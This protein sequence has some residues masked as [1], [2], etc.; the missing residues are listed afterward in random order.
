MLTEK[1]REIDRKKLTIPYSGPFDTSF[2]RLH[3]VRYADD[4]LIGVIGSKEDAIAIKEQVKSF[5]AD[6]LKLELSD[7]TGKRKH[8]ITSRIT[9]TSKSLTSTTVKSR[10][11]AI[12]TVSPTMLL[13]PALSVISCSTV[14][15]K[16]LRLNIA[17][18][19]AE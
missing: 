18:P 9:M 13:T 6:A 8:G 1:I 5:V 7:A 15:S 4:F 11:F 19:C 12:T 16:P 10:A 3:Y 14:C 17:P 2:K